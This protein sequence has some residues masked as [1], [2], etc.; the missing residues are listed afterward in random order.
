MNILMIGI[1]GSGKGTQAQRLTEELGLSHISTGEI[2]RDVDVN[3]PLGK[4]VRSYIDKGNLIPTDLMTE[5]LKER[6]GQKDCQNGAILEGYPRD[7]EQ[8]KLLE[9]FFPLDHVIL[10]KI[11]DQEALK[12]LTGRWICPK[13]EISYNVNTEPRPKV[14]GICDKCGSKLFQRK[15]ETPQAVKQRIEIFHNETEP[16][17]KYYKDQGILL[18]I[19]GEQSI[20]KVQKEIRE[21][22]EIK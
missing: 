13:C 4:K 16:L 1:Q 20:E 12:R 11:S 6:L 3:T 7:I 10:L 8:A 15:D 5:L 17:I 18:E 9:D 14:L 2:C 19:N 22:L 21:K